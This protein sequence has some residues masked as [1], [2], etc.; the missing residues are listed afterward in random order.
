MIPQCR[1]SSSKRTKDR[2]RLIYEN[3]NKMCVDCGKPIYKTAIRC[4]SC[5]HKRRITI[6]PILRE[7]LKNKIR[8]ESF[9]KIGKEFNVSDNAIRKW[10]KKYCLP[11]KTKEI[12]SYSD[13]EWSLL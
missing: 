1:L 12:K 11:Y 4:A 8:N 13:E 9:T 2:K 7:D 3:K 10:C 6:P 5:E